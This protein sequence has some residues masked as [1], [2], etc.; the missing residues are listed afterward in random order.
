MNKNQ[1]AKTSYVNLELAGTSM[2]I[3]KLIYRSKT[4]IYMF[5]FFFLNVFQKQDQ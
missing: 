5:F 3:E 1:C 2:V 4:P